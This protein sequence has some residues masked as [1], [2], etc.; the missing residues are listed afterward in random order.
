MSLY[1][2]Q[3]RLKMGKKLLNILSHL[4]QRKTDRQTPNTKS[5]HWFSF[6]FLSLGL[7]GKTYQPLPASLSPQVCIR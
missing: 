7:H 3:Y 4:T 1:S 6:L 5:A 2:L